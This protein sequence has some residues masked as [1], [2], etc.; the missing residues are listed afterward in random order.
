MFKPLRALASLL[1][2]ATGCTVTAPHGDSRPPDWESP[3][4]RIVLPEPA[5]PPP[6]EVPV[7]VPQVLPA[8]PLATPPELTWISLARWGRE[9]GLGEPHRLSL[10]PALTYALLTSNGVLVVQVGSLAAYWDRLEFRLGF[11]PQLIGDQV[12]MHALDL[13]KN[14]EPLVRGFAGLLKTNERYR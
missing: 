11:A 8:P 1:A 13:Q 14:L 10:S 7:V 4:N 3:E 6:P 2:L 12:F 9:R 5:P